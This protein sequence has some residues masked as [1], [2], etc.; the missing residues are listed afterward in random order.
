MGQV[1]GTA[2]DE[3]E[4]YILLLGHMIDRRHDLTVNLLLRSR[5]LQLLI[6]SRQED[7]IL[8]I[9]L[10]A[11]L[12]LG[13][14]EIGVGHEVTLVD[15]AQLQPIPIGNGVIEM[16]GLVVVDNHAVGLLGLVG[17]LQR[18]T[19]LLVGLGRIVV[20]IEVHLHILE[21]HLTEGG[22]SDVQRDLLGLAVSVRHTCIG[23][24]IL[25]VD[26]AGTTD[27]PVV[28][29][30]GIRTTVGIAGGIAVVDNLFLVVYEVS[31]GLHFL[32]IGTAIG[33]DPIRDSRRM[34]RVLLIIR[35]KDRPVVA[36]VRTHAMLVLSIDVTTAETGLHVDQ[37]KLCHTGDVT[38][39]FILRRTFLGGQLQVHT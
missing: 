29:R 27:E 3:V 19:I 9:G 17:I 1:V 15:L 37:L 23:G 26:V 20:G 32:Q 34:G 7:G 24:D 22:G 33:E 39:D 5:C 35:G 36:R 25:I 11:N 12:T 8:R 13:D 14:G 28:G 31:G 38:P 21:L 16:E 18:R 4:V 2:E 30:C 10:V 6:V